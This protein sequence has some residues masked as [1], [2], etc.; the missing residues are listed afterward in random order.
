VSLEEI[1]RLQAVTLTDREREVLAFLATEEG[2][3]DLIEEGARAMFGLEDTS[4]ALVNR[5]LRRM[6][7]T[8]T[9]YSD[10]GKSGATYYRIT[11]EGRKALEA[12]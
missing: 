5:L 12:E 2:D 9:D 10:V 8:P 6:F 1:R 7:I 11:E 3:G 4:V